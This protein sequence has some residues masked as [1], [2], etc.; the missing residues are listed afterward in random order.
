MKELII[1]G[2]AAQVPTRERNH[3]G[4]FLRW[5]T[6]GILF[7]PGEGTQRQMTYADV[8]ASSIQHIAL[9]HFHG[10]HCLGLPGVVQRINLD[11]AP[12]PVDIYYPAS[13]QAYLN[14]LLNTSSYKKTVEFQERPVDCGDE[15]SHH[16]S[17]GA[18]VELYRSDSMVILC[19]PIEHRVACLGY[20][21][22]EPE[23][24]TIL[25]EK[26]AQFGLQTGPA[27]GS[28]KKHGE[29]SLENGKKITLADVSVVRPGQSYAHIMDTRPCENAVKLAQ[30]V[31]IL[32]CEATFLDFEEQQA[33]EYMH[34]TARQAA[35]LA[36]EAGA[37]QLILT[38][39]SQRYMSLGEHLSQARE[40]FPET[41]VARDL[42]VFAFPKRVRKATNR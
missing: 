11:K 39:F 12:G 42:D 4:Y 25:P 21:I 8:R 27:V 23:S 33:K 40:I 29:L 5:E 26:L 1:L 15:G 28:L 17:N 35:I 19:A 18:L 37:K 9:T 24:H 16:A 7:D 36:R 14:H 13:G 41:R 30:N 6:E 32:L 20:R 22:E 31:D 10:D 34:M 3:N 2:T 38:H